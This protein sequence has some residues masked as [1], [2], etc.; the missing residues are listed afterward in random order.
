[1]NVKNKNECNSARKS[2]RNDKNVTSVSVKSAPSS[3]KRNDVNEWRSIVKNTGD[4]KFD[5][6]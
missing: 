5:I 1:M 3:V 6:K 2:D 4:S